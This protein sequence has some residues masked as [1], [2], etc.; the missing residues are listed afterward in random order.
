MLEAA[1]GGPGPSL[2][3]VVDHDDAEREYCY[4]NPITEI[5]QDRE[6]TVIS[7]KDDF[8]TVFEWQ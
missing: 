3:L 4:S 2:M 7:M 1:A 5:A 6:W 8:K